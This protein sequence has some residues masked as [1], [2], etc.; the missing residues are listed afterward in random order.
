MIVDP[1]K[2]KVKLEE[3]KEVSNPK[4]VKKRAKD[5]YNSDVFAST[6]KGKKYMIWNGMKWIHFGSIM[7]QDW[8]KHQDPIRR[9]SYLKRASNIKGKWKEDPYSPN[10]LAINLLW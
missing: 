4:L 3:L 2:Q 10:F 7:Y 5:I 1:D 9:E 8:T 6:R